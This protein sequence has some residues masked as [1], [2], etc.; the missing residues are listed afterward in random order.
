MLRK[1]APADDYPILMV[2]VEAHDLTSDI[3][4]ARSKLDDFLE[5]EVAACA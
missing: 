5:R 3:D 2:D 1:P 4:A